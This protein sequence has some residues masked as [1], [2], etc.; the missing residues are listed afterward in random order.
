M[1][2]LG[3]AEAIVAIA[4]EHAGGRHVEKIELKIG[5]LRQVVPDALTFAFELVAQGTSV[6][7]AILVIEDVP[8][9]IVCRG[10]ARDSRVTEFPFACPNC[11]SFDIN[12]VTGDELLVDSLE[13]VN[14]QPM[15]MAQEGR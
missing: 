7:G 13:I 9:R 10:C 15:P 8:V 3:I 2:E 11:G 4:E 14:E 12:V 1:H 6:E 5:H